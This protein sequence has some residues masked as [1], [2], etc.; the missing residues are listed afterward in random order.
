MLL[1]AVAGCKK[2]KLNKVPV[3]D[4]GPAQ[5]IQSPLDSVTLVGSGK[6]EDGIITGYLWSKVSGPNIPAIHTPGAATTIITGLTAGTYR[7]QLMVVDDDGA[8]GLDTVSVNVLPSLIKNLILQPGPAEG[9]DSRPVAVQGCVSGSQIGNAGN[10]ASPDLEDLAIA[11]WT[12]NALG[13]A[14]GQYRSFLKFTGLSVIPQ[15]ATVLSAKLSLYG[16]TTSLA[17]P[18]GNSY[19]PGSPYNSSGSNE[20]WIKRVTGNWAEATLTWNNQPGVTDVNRV[21]IPASTSQWGYSVTDIDVTELVKEMV[22]N[23]NSNHGFCLMHQVEQ[24][25]R[26]MS[27]GSSDNTD[28]ARRPKLVVTYK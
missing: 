27:F 1:M 13:C 18:Q 28:P 16:V 26:S 20:C 6:D 8:T 21:A 25:Y 3:A 17:S 15:N 5:T 14:T 12:F 22:N 4:A 2:I 24:Y 9:Q 7:F 10:S 11:A 23:A 19:Y